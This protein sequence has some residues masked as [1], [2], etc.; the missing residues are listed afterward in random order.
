MSSQV[1]NISLFVPYVFEHLDRSCINNIFEGLGSISTIDLVEKMKPNGRICTSAY[2]H[3]NNW[4]NTR[5]SVEFQQILLGPDEKV[6]FVYDD[7]NSYLIV[8]EN[9]VRKFVPGDRKKRIDLGDLEKRREEQEHPAASASMPATMSIAPG[10][11][12]SYFAAAVAATMD[13]APGLD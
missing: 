9:K 7:K 5:D 10:L 8:L 2:I 11:D 4:Y 3:F 1:K 12:Y 13:I 6:N